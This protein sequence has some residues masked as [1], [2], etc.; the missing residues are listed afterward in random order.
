MP[1]SSILV[2]MLA[3]AGALAAGATAISRPRV[4]LAILFVLASFSRA[5]LETP[6]GTMRL[7]MPAIAVVAA[8]LLAGGRLSTLR[9]LPRATLATALAFGTYLGVLALSS[10][11][12][13]PGTDQ[14]LHMVAWL[15]ISMMG[16][17]V[18]FVLVRPQPAG[19]IQSLAFGGAAMGVLG[20][21]VAVMFLVAGPA[22]NLGIQ[23]S[24]A[25][26]P[27]VYALGWEANL[28]A[29]FL[30]MCAFFALEA[31]RGPRR[32]AGV[33]MLALVLIGFPLGVTRGAYIGLAAGVLAYCAV[34]L[35]VGRRLAD[36][37]RLGALATALIVVGMVASN[38]LLPNAREREAAGGNVGQSP[39]GSPGSSGTLASPSG[40][41]LGTSTPA[42][43]LE[44]YPDT[45][46]FR[47]ERVP[48]ALD[49]LRNSPLIGFGAAAFG[50]RHPDRYAGPGPDHIAI[51]AVAAPYEAGI[52]GASALSIGF[53]LLLTSLWKSARRASGD[54]DW[55][56]VGAAAAF[57]GSLVSIL[58]AY[59]SN[60]AL[61]LA[62]NW[63]V[64]GA[65]AALTAREASRDSTSSG[66]LSCHGRGGR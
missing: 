23:E 28:Y 4:S 14:S 32:A 34:R 33:V 38:V 37:P 2:L 35:A 64:I 9:S 8:I 6:L 61:H 5:T 49:D 13:A 18:A 36:L 51:L 47:L 63:I 57:I 66:R 12:V 29:S 58:V 62:I 1:D 27:R 53:A 30:G 50:Q 60:N 65:A 59:Q 42:P 44:P 11:L 25:I 22:F 20:V 56:A 3:T 41:P 46:A 17:V 31:A 24:N 16:G 43:T 15:A 26:L 45:L 52:I 7:E 54:T 21:V 48:I 10:A 19:A 39:S 40:V 55:R